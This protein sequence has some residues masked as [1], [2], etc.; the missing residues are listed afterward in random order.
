MSA[1]RERSSDPSH[2][3]V[4]NRPTS[5]FDPVQAGC[6][7]DGSAASVDPTT[8]RSASARNSEKTNEKLKQR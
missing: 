8:S 6:D 5:W 4:G 7:P 1:Q 2:H 3:L